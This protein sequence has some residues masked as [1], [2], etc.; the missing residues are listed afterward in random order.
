MKRALSLCLSLLLILL[1]IPLGTF[2][3]NAYGSMSLSATSSAIGVGDEV[4]ITVA[5]SGAANAKS[6]SVALTL[7]DKVTF[8]SGEWLATDATLS[9]FN[10]DLQKGA[11]A[12]SAAQDLNGDLFRFVVK[13]ASYGTSTITVK[14]QLKNGPTVVEDMTQ[15]INITV[16]EEPTTSS[17]E[18]A[19]VGDGI[20]TLSASATSVNVYGETT[21]TVALSGAV[22]AR[23]GS[24]ALT[25][26]DKVSIVSGKWLVPKYELD[27]QDEPKMA[28]FNKAKLNGA[29]TYTNPTDVNGDYFRF[30]VKGVSE[31]TSTISVAIL[32]KVGPTVVEDMT[33][34]INIT[35]GE[36]A[37][38]SSEAATTS[39][40]AAAT[41]SEEPATSSEEPATPSEEPASVGDGII[42]LGASAASVKVGDETTI[43]VALSNTVAAKSG[44]VALTLDDKVSI[45]SGKWLVP[46]YELDDQDEPRIASFSKTTLKGAFAYTNPTDV[47]GNYF[48]FTVKGANIGTSTISVNVQLK[49]GSTVVEDMTK[50]I[51]IKV[52]CATHT[53][54]AWTQTKAPTCSAAGE[55]VHTCSVCGETETQTVAALGHSFTNYVSD[56]NATCTADGTKTAKCDR[57]AATN[58]VTD[59]GSALGHSFTNYVSDNNATCTAD[60]TKTAKCDRCTATDTVTDAGSALGHDYKAV[61]TAPTCTERG[62]TTHTCSRC[63]DSYVDSYVAAL[64]HSYT[65]WVRMT[66]PTCT[67]TGL[68]AHVCTVC[69]VTE[70]RTVA[71]LGHSFTNY[72]SDN[73][74][75]CT[76]DGT[77]TA[78][79]DRCTATDTVTDAGS[80]L[81]HDYQN[82]TLTKAPTCSATGTEIGVCARCSNVTSRAVATLPHSG[83]WTTLVKPTCTAMG[84]E[85]RV[86]DVCKT[87]ETRDTEPLGHNF[88]H[89]IDNGDG[90]WTGLC[91][92]CDATEIVDELPFVLGDFDGN[93]VLNDDDAIWLLLNT[94][95]PEEYPI[96]QFA[97]FDG[98]G[99]FNDD[100]AIWL[101]LHT[102]CPE[103]YP[104]A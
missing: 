8:V 20:M 9:T 99:V 73:N 30:V 21:I 77:K 38:T 84:K 82:W 76:A 11:I 53:W 18:P 104:I 86:C 5:L 43:T 65:D 50:S 57:C 60:G 75:T 91:D 101:L 64:G 81:G 51:D 100:D 93:G 42:A 6:G 90:T 15:T 59:A 83:E 55:K 14:V 35:V 78:K 41:S 31:G 19:S 36:A 44:S 62:Y 24:V 17:E 80:A 95:F 98:N 10:S 48:R 1:M 58:T 69:H 87:F 39:S 28:S 23:S 13:G 32:L 52:T 12:F 46:K 29:F 25:L 16:G 61:V 54:G 71:A 26:D 34:T 49:D 89:F 37:T 92:R 4:T 2:V 68:D 3:A 66:D 74:A 94:F 7:D 56:N 27:D 102:F 85:A 103:E 22:A 79:C 72:V 40:E 33:Q 97:D 96:Y 67:A 63:K 45:V 47:N 88:T 70:T